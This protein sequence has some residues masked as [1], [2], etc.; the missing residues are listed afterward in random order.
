M[1]FHFM[2]GLWMDDWGMETTESI[3][4]TEGAPECLASVPRKLL[5]K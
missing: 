4:I 1:T 3:V 5:V 2:T